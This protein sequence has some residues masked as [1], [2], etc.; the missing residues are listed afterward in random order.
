MNQIKN[1]GKKKDYYDTNQP[2]KSHRLHAPDSQTSQ[3]FIFHPQTNKVLGSLNPNAQNENSE[4]IH[5]IK[6][7]KISTPVTDS[8]TDTDNPTKPIVTPKF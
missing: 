4:P 6:K 1:I 3:D 2:K 5:Q 8:Q 7:L